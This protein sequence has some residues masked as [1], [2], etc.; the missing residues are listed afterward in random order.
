LQLQHDPKAPSC[1]YGSGAVQ[2][3]AGQA[4][5]P[6]IDNKPGVS[7]GVSK[8]QASGAVTAHTWMKLFPALRKVEKLE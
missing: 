2:S 4:S 8:Q 5:T 1:D 3:N 7:H 6:T